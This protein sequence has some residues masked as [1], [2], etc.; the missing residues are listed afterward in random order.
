MKSLS[1][2]ARR[3]VLAAYALGGSFDKEGQQ[4]ERAIDLLRQCNNLRTLLVKQQ[5]Q[6]NYYCALWMRAGRDMAAAQERMLTTIDT[7]RRQLGTFD[8]E[9]YEEKRMAQAFRLRHVGSADSPVRHPMEGVTPPADG[10]RFPPEDPGVGV[11][12]VRDPA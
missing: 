6:T 1:V 11:P 10:V 4:A 3:I 7:L 9:T 12:D 2:V 8:G 5:E